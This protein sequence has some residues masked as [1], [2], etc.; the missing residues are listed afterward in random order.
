M[1][2]IEVTQKWIDEN[3]E[4]VVEFLR[5][6]IKRPS[7][8]TFFAEEDEKNNPEFHER[9]CQE[10]VEGFLKEMGF[11]S[12]MW[13]PNA[14]HLSKYE[15]KAGYYAGRDFTNRPNLCGT[16]KGSGEGKSILLIGHIDV[17]KPGSKW[18]VDPFGATIKDGCVY[19]RGTVDMKGGIAAM[20]MAVKAIHKSGLKLKGDILVGTV[21]DEEAGGMGTLAFVDRGYRADGCVMTEP[22]GLNLA[23]LCRGILWGKLKISGR[24][25]HIELDQQDWRTGGAVDAIDK[26][27]LYCEQFKHLNKE[28]SVT[29]RHPL[30]PIPCQINIA[31]FNAGEFPTSYANN[32]ELVFNT[33]YLPTERDENGLGGNIKR[34]IEDFV[35]KVAKTDSWLSQNIPEI[36][37][38]VDAD[39]GETSYDNEFV[40]TFEKSF[41]Q[42]GE[43][44][45]VEGICCHTDMGW[46]VNV[47][48][49]TVNFGPGEP[50]ISHQA[51]EHI[52]IDELLRAT[53]ILA[54][55]IIN[56]CGVEE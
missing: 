46:L 28:W 10:Y 14:D 19:G 21:A 8:N 2:N 11:I 27:L 42:S 17:V 22:T 47:G 7:I 13:E 25:G 34:F 26:A 6:I 9:N 41:V 30:L 54:A 1:N 37:W 33:Q 51:D 18:T 29:R 3:S 40:Q 15:G 23:P 43:E 53:K 12:D 44:V 56:W 35:D 50:R 36:E 49:P 39:C 55:T 20:I 31:Q 5:E 38:L 45:K 48:M 16:L 4:D 52:S 24:A 32:A